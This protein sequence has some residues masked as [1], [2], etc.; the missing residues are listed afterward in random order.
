MHW[1]RLFS[2]P[3]L[4][5]TLY[6]SLY[7]VRLSMLQPYCDKNMLHGPS[8][9][10]QFTILQPG[11]RFDNFTHDSPKRQFSIFFGIILPAMKQFGKTCFLYCYRFFNSSEIRLFLIFFCYAMCAVYWCFKNCIQYVVEENHK[12]N[13]QNDI[14]VKKPRTTKYTCFRSRKKWTE[15]NLCLSWILMRGGAIV[16][17][18][19]GQ[20]HSS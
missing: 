17:F 15:N 5:K 11:L 9:R 16:H 13:S 19:S 18:A 1:S 2:A 3:E 14:P 12:L 10:L 4:E 20:L 6:L 8:I 7:S